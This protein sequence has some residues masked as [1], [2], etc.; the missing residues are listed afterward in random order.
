MRD[1][2]KDETEG[3]RRGTVLFFSVNGVIIRVSDDVKKM[4]TCLFLIGELDG[5]VIMHW[6]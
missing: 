4:A 2:S 3:I 6:M 5:L 1:E